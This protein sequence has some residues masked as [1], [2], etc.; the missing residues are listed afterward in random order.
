MKRN[1]IRWCKS[2]LPGTAGSPVTRRALGELG[3]FD[4]IPFGQMTGPAGAV[5]RLSIPERARHSERIEN[6]ARGP[7]VLPVTIQA[8]LGARWTMSRARLVATAAGVVGADPARQI[9]ASGYRGEMGFVVEQRRGSLHLPMTAGARRR[10]IP[11]KREVMTPRAGIRLSQ[12]VLMFAMGKV[13][14]DASLIA[15]DPENG[16]LRVDGQGW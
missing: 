3:P 1:L 11:R 16:S 5:H 2:P 13:G 15:V 8:W 6:L 12:S 14:G 4:A 9:F 10:V 7:H